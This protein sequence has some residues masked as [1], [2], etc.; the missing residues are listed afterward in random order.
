VAEELARQGWALRALV[1]DA[2]RGAEAARARGLD[3]ELVEGDVLDAEAL[4]RAARGAEVVVHGVNP[5]YDRWEEL[6]LPMADAIADVAAQTGATL[7]FPGNVY[8]F[9][10]GVG[11][12]EDTPAAPPTRKGE[13]RVEVEARLADAATRGA[14]VI[15]LRGGD[16]FGEGHSSSWMTEI[17][18]A[19]ASGG[20]ISMPLDDEVRHAFCY[21]PDFVRAHVALLERGDLPAYAVFHFAGHVLT[22]K[23]LQA[24]VRD[25]VSDPGRKVR[26][27]PW[28]GVRAA[29]WFKPVMGEIYAMRYLWQQEVVLD[30]SRLE[31]AL[32]QVPHTPLV[33]ALRHDLTLMGAAR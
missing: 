32:G 30:Q 10:P 28:W 29:G 19:A 18:G 27:I 17:L 1:R 16:F 24:S 33:E 20:A 2:A 6:V 5:T 15:I 26:R 31:A 14:R 4:R 22:G 3:V 23:E 13:L 11:I 7:L 8:N 25:A 9:A 21:L 12:D